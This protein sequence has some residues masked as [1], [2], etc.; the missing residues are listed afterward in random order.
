MKTQVNKDTR[1]PLED[2]SDQQW[3]I[4]FLKIKESVTPSSLNQMTVIPEPINYRGTYHGKTQYQYYCDFIND[5]LLNIRN[6]EIDYC[7]FIY[8]ISELL[9]YEHDRLYAEWLPEDRCFKLCLK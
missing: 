1:K 3:Q 9:K 4:D 6:G 2:Y 8:Q 7:F 5:I